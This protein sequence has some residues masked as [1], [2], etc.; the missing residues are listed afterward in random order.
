MNYA[1]F[2]FFDILFKFFKSKNAP[3]TLVKEFTFPRYGIGMLSDKIA[4]GIK[5]Q[6][7]KICL[8]SEVVEINH[9]EDKITSVIYNEGGKRK[10]VTAENYISTMPINELVLKLNPKSSEEV[11]N[12]A[13]KL[14][15]VNEI[16]IFLA[17]NKDVVSNDSWIYFPSKDISFVRIHE[18]KN[19]SIDMCEKGKSSIVAE[20]ICGK[21]SNLWDVKDEEL[22][23]KVVDDLVKLKFIKEDEVIGHKVIKSQKTYPLYDLDYKE[24]RRFIVDYLKRF[25]NLYPIGRN[26]Y[27]RYNNIDHSIEMGIK[28]AQNLLGANNNLDKIGTEQEYF[29]QK[30]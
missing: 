17:I 30:I 14:N 16:F 10:V 4:E 12:Y 5:K 24:N 11:I 9:S 27:F 26:G 28:A 13:R 2:E 22:V 3:K 18:P 15:Y 21:G 7:G 25:K 8:N 23:K 19:W 1:C 29:E 20:Y 6:G